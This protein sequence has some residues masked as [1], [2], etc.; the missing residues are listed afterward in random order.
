[1]LSVLPFMQAVPPLT[2]ARPLFM[3]ECSG[4]APVYTASAPANGGTASIYVGSARLPKP[5][6]HAAGS[7]MPL[8]L[9]CSISGTAHMLTNAV[10]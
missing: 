10:S 5:P 7:P 1:M 2:A 8:C 6:T 4:I 3:V 9:C